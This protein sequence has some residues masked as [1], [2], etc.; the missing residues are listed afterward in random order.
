MFIRYPEIRGLFLMEM[1]SSEQYFYWN[2][3]LKMKNGGKNYLGFLIPKI[4]QIL[5][6]TLQDS[7][8]KHKNYD[9]KSVYSMFKN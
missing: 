2:H 6:C 9:L 5:K 4:L 7:F 8:N 3:L 1:S